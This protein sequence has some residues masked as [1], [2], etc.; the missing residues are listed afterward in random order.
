MVISSFYPQIGG[1]EKQAFLLARALPKFGVEATILTRRWPGTPQREN[2][3][4]VNVIRVGFHHRNKIG[5]ALS[6]G[7]WLWFCWKN[8][9]FFDVYHAHQPFSS[10]LVAGITGRLT[11]KPTICKIPGTA[12]AEYFIRQKARPLDLLLDAVVVVNKENKQILGEKLK[13]PKIHLIP[14]GIDFGEVFRA[15][16]RTLT[17]NVVLTVS[18]LEPGKGVDLLLRA[19]SRVIS[20]CPAAQLIVIGSGT[21]ELD[22][23]L[24]SRKLGIHDRV[25]FIGRIDPFNIDN[26][27][28]EAV[29]YVSP[30]F[31][32]GI[33]NS[34]LEAIR[35]GVPVVASRIP[36]NEDVV[37][38]GETGLLFEPNDPEA[39]A[40]EIVSVLRDG[41][42]ARHLALKAYEYVRK[43]FDINRVAHQYAALYRQLLEA[44]T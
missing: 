37:I 29:C 9:L 16:P 13:R 8:S 22:L 3:K 30:S 33:S 18:R 40:E 23:K 1:A 6:A 34:L 14:N 12:S 25:Q 28:R 26:Y 42:T 5:S 19:W 36:G 2:L 21:Q 24:L 43:N 44:R 41:V 4:G 20:V 38:H 27:Y 39:L 11:G 31:Y 10:A 17:S 32:E 35:A 15:K 7:V